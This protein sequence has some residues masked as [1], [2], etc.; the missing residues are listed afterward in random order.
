VAAAAVTMWVI[1]REP[2]PQRSA[3]DGRFRGLIEAL[4]SVKEQ[5][6]VP[7]DDEQ[8]LQG[9]I[10][11]MVG[12]LDEFSSYIPAD[13]A[14]AFARRMA[15]WQKGLGL[16]VDLLDGRAV[17]VG[18]LHDSPAHREGFLPGD[19]IVRIDGASAGELHL[20]DI[21]AR[22][23]TRDEDD[24]VELMV[25]PAGGGPRIVALTPAEF[26]VESVTG[27]YRD[28]NGQWIWMLDRRDFSTSSGQSGLAY[29]R[30]REFV[31]DTAKR[32][33][34]AL[35]GV[36]NLHGLVLD[37]R[38]NPGG[39]GNVA[40]QVADTFLSNGPLVTMVDRTGRTERHE[41]HDRGT[42]PDIPVVVLI[43]A[44][45]ASGAEIVAGALYHRHR[46]V[47][48]GTRTRGK[49]CVQS[50]FVLADGLGQVN[51]TT[52][53][54]V[55][56]SGRSI[57]RLPGSDRWGIDPHEQ[58]KIDATVHRALRRLR[59]QCEVPGGMTS[60]TLPATRKSPRPPRAVRELLRLDRQLAHSV[61]LLAEP[62]RMQAILKRAAAEALAAAKTRAAAQTRAT[63]RG[64]GD[65]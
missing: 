17:I 59:W 25:L 32:L 29:V 31:N 42:L 14:G 20:E 19:R 51:L 46:A 54:F 28:R 49:G 52:S 34:A 13:K 21:E 56:S 3:D 7:V 5:Y 6:Y 1:P 18:V 23:N 62:L 48:V 40:I 53:Q 9:A 2:R 65:D 61:G 64:G 16:R 39:K 50:M 12:S 22:L 41:A 37:L 33:Q 38:D 45:T 35:Q 4:H 58:V 47:L 11:G 27:L 30:I 36:P 24:T 44:K 63:R 10:S 15:G 57:I 26:H 60:T 8:L 55:F 43:D